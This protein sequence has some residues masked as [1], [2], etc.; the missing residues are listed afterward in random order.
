MH[1]IGDQQGIVRPDISATVYGRWA[2]VSAVLS[3]EIDAPVVFVTD[4]N[5]VQ[6]RDAISIP[7][8]GGSGVLAT[9][10]AA[11]SEGALVV[12]SQDAPGAF[13]V[14]IRCIP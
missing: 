3:G 5:G 12:Y 1:A 14:P 4:A 7:F 13:A 6:A 2:L 10:I 8:A 9:R 11:T